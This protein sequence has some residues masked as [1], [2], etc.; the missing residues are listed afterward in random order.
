ME[1][2]N[3]TTQVVPGKFYLVQH[4]ILEPKPEFPNFKETLFIPVIGPEH[5]DK[6][7]GFPHTHL[8]IDGRF[9]KRREYLPY[10]V[11]EK[12]ETAGVILT[13]NSERSLQG[14][15][16]TGL[17]YKKLKCIRLTTGLP[18]HRV[19]KNTEIG[20]WYESMEGKSCKGKKCPHLGV[21]MQEING[22]L[23]C[24]LHSLKAD[25][26]TQTI[27]HRNYTADEI[28]FPKTDKEDNFDNYL[29]EKKCT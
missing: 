25:I 27:Q 2:V 8:H 5:N 11:D 9:C 23:I 24:P 7:F 20:K 6:Q 26:A 12:G 17:V 4:A 21:A 10:G 16:F 22:I 15:L 3:E 19:S 13:K 1:T 18:V 29:K 14:H 28:I